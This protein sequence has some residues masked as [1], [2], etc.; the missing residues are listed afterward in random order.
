MIP[1]SAR[2]L[3]DYVLSADVRRALQGAR[4]GRSKQTHV[5]RKGDSLW[6]ISRAYR[7]SMH[8]LAAWNGISLSD[9]LRPGQRLTIRGSAGP[10]ETPRVL[11]V[12]ETSLPN[13]V[14]GH[15]SYTVR[16]GDSL[17]QISRRFNVSVGALIRWNELTPGEHLQPGQ[18][19]NVYTDG[20][21]AKG[22]G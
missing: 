1:V 6:S 7:I 22:S 15:V 13:T 5:V 2:S 11:S 14:N 4:P 17:W 12:G 8:R 19:L 9:V 10:Q 16:R 20:G 3:D 18:I 21:R